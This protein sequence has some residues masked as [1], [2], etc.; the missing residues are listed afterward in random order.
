MKFSTLAMVQHAERNGYAV[1]A[2]NVFDE[3]SLRGVVRAAE[4]CSSPIIVQIST[5][6]ARSQGVRLITEILDRVAGPS[7]IP[8]AL[9]L[10]HCPDREVID[11]VVAAGWSSLL[12]DASDLDLATAEQQTREVVRKAHAAGVSL[13]T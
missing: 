5:K 2:V 11:E 13:G 10:D 12:F 8:I 1:P 3:H 9:H 6:T 7:A 4:R